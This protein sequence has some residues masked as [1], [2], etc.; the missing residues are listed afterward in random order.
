M[1]RVAVSLGADSVKELRKLTGAGDGCTSCHKRLNELIE[2]CQRESARRE[3]VL[4]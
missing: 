3:L 2:L 1:V 4:A